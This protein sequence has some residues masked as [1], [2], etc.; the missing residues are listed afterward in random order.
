MHLLLVCAE[1][2]HVKDEFSTEASPR[3]VVDM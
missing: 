1:K 3:H 2:E